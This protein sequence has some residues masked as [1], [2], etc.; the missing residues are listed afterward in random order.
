LIWIAIFVKKISR[1]LIFG[2]P[3]LSG[4]LF[5][6]LGKFERGQEPACAQLIKEKLHGQLNGRAT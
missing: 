2:I 1:R 3:F 4:A 5:L 6:G